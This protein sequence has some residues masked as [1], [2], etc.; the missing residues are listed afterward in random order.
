MFLSK[1]TYVRV[2]SCPKGAWINKYHPELFPQDANRLSR[3]RTGNEVGV[4]ARN[5]FGPYVDVTAY[6]E[7]C[8]LDL[9]QMIENTR[10]EMEQGTPVICEA[11]FSFD[12]LYCAVD[13]LKKRGGRL[14]SL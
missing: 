6:K 5:L 1:S 2:W 10:R 13:L 9:T 3:L 8:K 14:G 7:E 12:G 4:L 11:S